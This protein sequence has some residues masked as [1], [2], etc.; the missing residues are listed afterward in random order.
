MNSLVFTT[1]ILIESVPHNNPYSLIVPVTPTDAQLVQQALS[2]SQAAYRDLVSRYANPA[3]NLACRMVQN[4][5]V[6]EELAQEAFARAFERLSTYDQQRRFVSWFFQILHNVT[7]DYLRQKR[8]VTIS[9]DA[10]AEAGHP[11]LDLPSTGA[12]PDLRIE[13]SEMAD[14]LD[15]A[16]ARIRPEYREAVVLRYRE[17][18]STQEVADA[19]GVPVGT[20]KTYLNRA[21]KELAAILA[22]EGWDHAHSGGIES[23]R[24]KIP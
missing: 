2:G 4:R 18:L 1:S 20:A 17:D 3:V 24:R 8:P 13:Q 16:L 7:V 10:L 12:S 23:T 22:A 14:S 11:L 9:L 15:S 5:A 19:M 6:A 21:R